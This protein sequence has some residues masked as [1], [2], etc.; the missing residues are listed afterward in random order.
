[1]YDIVFI[2]FMES[3]A[4]ENWQ[5][6]KDWFPQAKRLHGIVGLHVAHITAAHMVTTPMFYCVDGDALLDSTFGFDYVVPP[7][8]I[9]H[10]HVFRAKNPINDLV[11]GYGAV[12]LLPTP[13]VKALQSKDFKPDMTTSINRKYKVIQRLSNITAFNTDDY[14]AWRSAFR[15]CAKLSSQVIDGQVANETAWRLETWCTAG[16]DRPHGEAC[17]AGA[18]AGKEFGMRYAYDMNKLKLI[19]NQE[20]LASQYQSGK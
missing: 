17:M 8:E 19:N 12:K 3:N 18:R 10:V 2:S 6:L 15:E 14:N 7:Q 13:D 11:Y 20:W 9:D 16:A 1:V 4:E 5:R